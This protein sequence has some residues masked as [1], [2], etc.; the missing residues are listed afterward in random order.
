MCVGLKKQ[1]TAVESSYFPTFCIPLK[2]LKDFNVNFRLVPVHSKRLFLCKSV[3]TIILFQS[4]CPALLQN[5]PLTV[6]HQGAAV[7]PSILTAGMVLY[8]FPTPAAC[9]SQPGRVCTVPNSRTPCS[10]FPSG[11]IILSPINIFL[12]D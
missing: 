5:V 2:Q 4:F 8:S 1:C 7:F 12:H 10:S 9:L 6:Y 11:I 3:Q